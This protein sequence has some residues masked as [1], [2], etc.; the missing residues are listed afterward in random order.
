[1]SKRA[2]DYLNSAP[3]PIEVPWDVWVLWGEKA[4]YI[5]FA[6]DQASLGEDYAHLG[7]IRE[8]LEW[9]CDQFG[10]SVKWKK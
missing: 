10:G 5:D 7:K 6:G 1:M 8:A 4:K 2:V 3:L 9:Y